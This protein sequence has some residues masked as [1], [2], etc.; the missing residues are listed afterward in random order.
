MSQCPKGYTMGPAGVCIEMQMRQGGQLQSR[1]KPVPSNQN[2]VDGV[3]SPSA[4]KQRKHFV[5][6]TL[7]HRRAMNRNGTR[8]FYCE[9]A[10]CCEQIDNQHDCELTF[11]I[12]EI[13]NNSSGEGICYNNGDMHKKPGLFD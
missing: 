3:P 5:Q 13:A 8:E 7:A 11:T 6:P 10:N 2:I 1:T 12:V 9:G 4:P